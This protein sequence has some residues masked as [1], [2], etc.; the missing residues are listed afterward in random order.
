[1][2]FVIKQIKEGV[3]VQ[4]LLLFRLVFQA[5]WAAFLY[6][7]LLQRYVKVATFVS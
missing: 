4:S 3:I 5:G 1:M 6:S 7:A 2:I